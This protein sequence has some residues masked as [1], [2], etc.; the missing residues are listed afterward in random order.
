MFL[1]D[2]DDKFMV[3]S[4]FIMTCVKKYVEISVHRLIFMKVRQM[5]SHVI[6]F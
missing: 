2:F 5:V 3:L 1:E 4:D 6:I